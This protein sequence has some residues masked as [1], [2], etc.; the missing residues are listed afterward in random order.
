MGSSSATVEP[1]TVVETRDS[2]SETYGHIPVLVFDDVNV[3]LGGITTPEDA[4]ARII[5]SAG[6][7]IDALDKLRDAAVD[8]IA[9][10]EDDK[11]RAAIDAASPAEDHEVVA[12]WTRS[13]AS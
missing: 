5:T 8:R 4:D 12:E 3:Y 10:V 6:L 1:T 11:L 2:P 13:A 9:A 7:L